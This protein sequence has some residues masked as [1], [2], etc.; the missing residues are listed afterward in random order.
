VWQPAT[1]GGGTIAY[2]SADLGVRDLEEAASGTD[3]WIIR[4]SIGTEIGTVNY[5]VDYRAGRVLFTADQSGSAYYLTAYTYDIHAAA[6]DL[7]NERLANFTAWYD[8]RS[9]NQT[10]SRSQVFE[11]AKQM[12]ATMRQKAGSNITQGELHTALFFRS[13]IRSSYE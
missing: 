10:L 12:A 11:H 1:I 2:Y 8:F 13:D 3:R 7:W 6:A 4:D 5:T 9:D